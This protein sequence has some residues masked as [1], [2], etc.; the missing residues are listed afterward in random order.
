[1]SQKWWHSLLH[2]RLLSPKGLLL[3]AA[4]LTGMFLIVHLAGLREYTVILSGTSPTGIPRDAWGG[5]LGVAYVVL[6]FSFVLGVPILLLGA[7]LFMAIQRIVRHE[8]S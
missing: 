4:A 8:G 2:A 1:M 6:Y 5:S 7:A 3:R